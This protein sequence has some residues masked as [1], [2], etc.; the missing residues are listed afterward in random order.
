ML[1]RQ[2]VAARKPGRIG[3]PEI[4]CFVCATVPVKSRVLW[5]AWNV[6][7]NLRLIGGLRYSDD[8]KE[9]EKTLY[10]ADPFTENHNTQLAGLFDQVLNFSTDHWFNSQ[11]AYVCRGVAYN[12]T[13]D[14]DFD[15]KREEDHW[16]GDIT[17]QWDTTD[18]IMSYLKYGTGY[19]AGGFD[20]D[21]QK[22]ALDPSRGRRVVLPWGSAKSSPQVHEGDDKGDDD[23]ISP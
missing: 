7:D 10:H 22:G 16:T 5:G 6:A 14:T 23:D 20:E 3:G 8:T 17:L 15:N 9:L 4:E 11:G 13:L 2:P 18:S 21:N 12:C 19:K 1:Q